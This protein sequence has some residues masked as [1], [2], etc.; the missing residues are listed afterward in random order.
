MYGLPFTWALGWPRQLT[1]QPLFVE[2]RSQRLGLEVLKTSIKLCFLEQTENE[3]KDTIEL[4]TKQKGP[5]RGHAMEKPCFVALWIFPAS[6]PTTD[7]IL[8]DKL[9]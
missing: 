4:S 6:A 1:V 7:H 3:Q 5:G 8:L 2:E 9:A